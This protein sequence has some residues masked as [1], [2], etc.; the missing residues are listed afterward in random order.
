MA[1]YRENTGRY[2]LSRRRVLQAVTAAGAGGLSGCGFEPFDRQGP[3]PS[4]RLFVENRTGFPRQIALSVTDDAQN[5]NRIV[6][7]E[8]HIP[9]WHALEFE[10]VL[11]PGRIYDIR[12]FQPNVPEGGREKLVLEVETCTSGDPADQMDVSILASASGPDIISY[13]CDEVYAKTQ[14]LTYVDAAEY[15]TGAITGTIPSPT[16]S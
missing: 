4:G 9:E 10:E 3:V 14:S 2:T 16:P 13:N 11:E 1:T 6:H 5:G 15:E 12:A 8:Y 7:H